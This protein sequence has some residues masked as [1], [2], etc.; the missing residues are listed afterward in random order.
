MKTPAAF[1]SAGLACLPIVGQADPFRGL[2]V[3]ADVNLVD[4]VLGDPESDIT[5]A[6]GVRVRDYEISGGAEALALSVRV[7]IAPNGETL[8]MRA[9][10]YRSEAGIEI[11]ATTVNDLLAHVGGRA[12]LDMA[13][14][15]M[16]PVDDQWSW[17]VTWPV[18]G[19]PREYLQLTFTAD[20]L[21]EDQLS[22]YVPDE[23][24]L[25]AIM[26]M[27]MSVAGQSLDLHTLNGAEQ[28]RMGRSIRDL[29]NE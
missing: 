13:H 15:L 9:E 18:A 10:T 20:T 26:V 16:L 23:A 25:S 17:R 7:W 11:G 28:R 22:T 4:V 6:Q 29:L 27:S 19:V 3:G 14:T 1:L 24:V 21:P 2:T 5:T 12:A 8:A